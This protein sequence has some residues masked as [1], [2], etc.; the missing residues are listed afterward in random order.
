MQSN[1]IAAFLILG[2]IVYVTVKGEIGQYRQVL[3]V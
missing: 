3:G 1:Y 2:F